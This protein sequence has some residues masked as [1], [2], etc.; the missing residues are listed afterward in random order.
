M[1]MLTVFDRCA[2]KNPADTFKE[3]RLQYTVERRKIKTAQKLSLQD[4]KTFPSAAGSV[5]TCQFPAVSFSYI[6][7]AK[8]SW[9]SQGQAPFFGDYIHRPIN[10]KG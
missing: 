2:L 7:L 8:K 6:V 1:K 10:V 5:T 3:Q 9:L 4:L